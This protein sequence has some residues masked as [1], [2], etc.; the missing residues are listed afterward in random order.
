MQLILH[1]IN[2]F[3]LIPF[4]ISLVG[5]DI[6]RTNLFKRGAGPPFGG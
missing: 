1:P 6:L 5:L 2:S 4:M 3:L